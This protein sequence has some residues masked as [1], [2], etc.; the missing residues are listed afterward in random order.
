M[1]Y[2]LV[3]VFFLIQQQ[4]IMMNEKNI[5]IKANAYKNLVPF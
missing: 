2:I 3:F 1:N 4:N 5:N